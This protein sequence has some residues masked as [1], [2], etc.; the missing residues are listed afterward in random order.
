MGREVDCLKD[1]VDVLRE[2]SHNFAKHEQVGESIILDFLTLLQELSE[3]RG[4]LSHFQ[5]EGE[6][7]SEMLRRR[8]GDVLPNIAD[9]SLQSQHRTLLSL[10]SET[11]LSSPGVSMDVLNTSSSEQVCNNLLTCLSYRFGTVHKAKSRFV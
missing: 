6:D 8:A 5:V 9:P 3:I 2:S 11:N 7:I 1:Q 10:E 4:R